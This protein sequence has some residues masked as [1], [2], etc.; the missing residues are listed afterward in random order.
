M[1]IVME[2]PW[3]NRRV[4]LNRI[5]PDYTEYELIDEMGNTMDQEIVNMDLYGYVHNLE[6][7]TQWTLLFDDGTDPFHRNWY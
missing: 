1:T 4:I 6:D 7:E 2:D 3:S 5:N